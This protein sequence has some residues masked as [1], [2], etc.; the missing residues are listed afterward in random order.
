VV[1]AR[2]AAASAQVLVSAPAQ[3]LVVGAGGN[4]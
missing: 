4:K 1:S 3:V 2:A